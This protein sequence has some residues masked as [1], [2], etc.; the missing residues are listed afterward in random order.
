VDILLKIKKLQKERGLNNAQLAKKAGLTP[1]TIQGLYRRNNQPTIPTLTAICKAFG[2][3]IA[4]FFSD[5]D[6][7]PDLTPE[8]ISLLEHWNHITDDQKEALIALIKSM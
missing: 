6:V 8:Q 1:S 2:I 4:Q 5:S 3:T 7:P